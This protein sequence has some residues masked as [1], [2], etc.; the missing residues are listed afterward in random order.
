[1]S[2]EPTWEPWQEDARRKAAFYAK[3]QD[4]AASAASVTGHQADHDRVT[5][6]S[7]QAGIFGP[8][9]TGQQQAAEVAGRVPTVGGGLPGGHERPLERHGGAWDV[10][11]ITDSPCPPRADL[12]YV[13]QTPR[14]TGESPL[15]TYMRNRGQS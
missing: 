11:A 1:M 7:G 6:G 10:A 5:A 8:G 4:L 13:D 9:A 14:P 12:R 3:A 15:A 2:D